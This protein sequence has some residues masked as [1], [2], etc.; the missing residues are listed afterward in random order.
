MHSLTGDRVSKKQD[1]DRNDRAGIHFQIVF[2]NNIFKYNYIDELYSLVDLVFISI[3]YT[4]S[5]TT[6]SAA[7]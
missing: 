5:F 1:L 2:K 3:L 4:F 6:G 7:H